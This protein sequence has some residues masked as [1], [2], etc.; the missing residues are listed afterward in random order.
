M[1]NGMNNVVQDERYLLEISIK[2]DFNV[3]GRNL[4]NLRLLNAIE[5]NITAVEST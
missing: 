4:K 1:N 3:R 5:D 2:Y